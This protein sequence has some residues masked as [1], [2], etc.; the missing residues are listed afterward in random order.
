MNVVFLGSFYPT[1]LLCRIQNSKYV[2]F[3][4]DLLQKSYLQGLSH[5]EKVES[6]KAISIP[7]IISFPHK[8]SMFYYRGVQENINGIDCSTVSFLNLC[9]IKQ[10]FKVF[11]LKRYL[12]RN[13]KYFQQANYLFVYDLDISFLEF[14]SFLKLRYP[15]LK[16]VNIVPDLIGYTGLKENLFNKWRQRCKDIR[17]RKLL[18]NVDF[19]IFLTK[20]M[21]AYLDIKQ[22][23]GVLE[24]IYNMESEKVFSK[25][26]PNYNNPIKSVLY[27]GAMSKRNG[28]DKLLAAFSFI[29]D[30]N[31]R[32]VLCGDG[33]LRAQIEKNAE[34]DHRISFMGNIPHSMVLKLQ[35]EATLLINPRPGVEDFTKYSFPSKTMEYFASGVPVLMYDLLGVPREYYKYCF[36]QRELS[37]LSLS[38]EIYRICNLPAIQ[39]KQMGLSARSYVINNKTPVRSI[40]T[41]FSFLNQQL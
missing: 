12:K 21:A 16:V 22:P 17:V 23:F 27:S 39:R 37:S 6:F 13:E 2:G 15:H 24:G 32:L 18:F 31:F 36:T 28:V 1:S 20:D 4:N 9:S 40:E 10:K 26:I 35:L 41:V 7:N 29:S 5:S 38:R 34:I 30:E 25:N 33:E 3:A 11:G 14:V 19:F 8:T